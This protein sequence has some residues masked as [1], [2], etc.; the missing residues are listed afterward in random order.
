[1]MI[2]P[3]ILIVE[4][5]WIV[6]LDIQKRLEHFGYLVV[7]TATSGKEAIKSVSELHPDIVLM[8]INLDGSMDG[9]ETAYQ[10]QKKFG[11]PIV[12]LTAFSDDGT[13]RRAM[14]INPSAYIVKPYSDQELKNT[15]NDI[16]GKS[17]LNQ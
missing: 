4:D 17:V 3:R 10:I 2:V 5:N 9:I 8:D 14:R 1:M 12:F 16:F 7:G 15:L 11:L 13:K 6:S